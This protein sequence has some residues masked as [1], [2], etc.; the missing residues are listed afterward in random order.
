[1][2]DYL[3]YRLGLKNGTVQKPVKEKK[4]IAKKSA[5]KIAE[6]KEAKA[7]PSSLNYYFDY[8]MANAIP[9]C[10]NCGFEAAWLKDEKYKK[11]WKACQ[12]HVLPKRK[13]YGFPSLAGNLDNHLVLFPSFGGT[14]CGCHGFFDSSWFNATTM[15]VWPKAVDIFKKLQPLIPKEER[16][17]IPEQF[18]KP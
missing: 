18:L 13:E 4:P 9:K 3:Q 12:A 10:M 15:E 6:E 8:H 11:I 16:K 14:L 7:K 17:N 2:S 5:K 1:M